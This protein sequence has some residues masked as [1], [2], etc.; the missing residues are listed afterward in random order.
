MVGEGRFKSA[1]S[2]I[3]S[4]RNLHGVHVGRKTINKPT[5]G[6]SLPCS[7]DPEK[8]PVD[9]QSSP[10]PPPIGT[11]VAELDYGCLV[12]PHLGKW[13]TFSAVPCQRP[14]DR[15]LT[16][17]R[18]LPE[19]LPGCQGPSGGWRWFYPWWAF[20]RVVKSP[21]VLRDRNVNGVVHRDI[22][23]DSLVPFARKHNFR[24]QDDNTM[25][26]RT[27]VVIDYL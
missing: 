6:Q 23:W 14:H 5:W 20:H 19:R 27:R 8:A 26:H 18:L 16:A 2:L 12:P 21:L 24:Y 3:E 15:S 11:E 7:Q 17:R 1:R 9:C 25:S 4:L 10:D 22:L 13:V